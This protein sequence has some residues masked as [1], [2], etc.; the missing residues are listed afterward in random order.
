MCQSCQAVTINGLVCHERG[1][2]DA[3]KDY[4]RTCKWCGSEFT[5]DDRYQTCCDEDCISAYYGLPLYPLE[6]ETED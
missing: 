6:D 1:C 2:P 5:P 4:K 3:W